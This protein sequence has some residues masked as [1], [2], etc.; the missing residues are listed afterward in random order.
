MSGGKVELAEGARNLLFGC[1]GFVAGDEIL[2]VREDPASGW[3]DRAAPDAV[4]AEARAA[5]LEVVVADTGPPCA[6]GADRVAEL[7]ADHPKAVFFARIGD[8]TRFDDLGSGRMLVMSY[9][10]TKEALASSFG[11]FDHRAMAEFKSAIDDILASAQ[12]VAITCPN[13]TSLSGELTSDADAENAEVSVNRFP[14][15][16]PQPVPANG[17]SGRVCISRPLAPT[18]SGVYDPPCLR[19]KSP[20]FVQVREGR[21]TGFEGEDE[22]V[23]AAERHYRRVA[24]AFGIEP[25]VVHSWH[26][27]I[28]PGCTSADVWDDADLWANTVFNHPRYLHFHTCGNYAPG[29]ISWTLADTT[30]TIDGTSMWDRGRIRVENFAPLAR[31]LAEWPDLADLLSTTPPRDDAA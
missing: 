18:G 14:L 15:G 7:M 19:V 4:I 12:N 24:D 17:L 13:G 10:R 26:A 1:A 6:R 3:Y 27:G 22:D 2:V 25:F 9:A 20:V 31:C 28:H 29:E 5:G 11:R 21:I 30:V 16:V 8:Q 23:S